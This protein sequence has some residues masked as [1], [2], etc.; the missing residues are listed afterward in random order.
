[1]ANHFVELHS[2]CALPCA[3]LADEAV[4]ALEHLKLPGNVRQLENVICRALVNRAVPATLQLRDLPLEVLSE[5][6]ANVAQPLCHLPPSGAHDLEG[7]VRHQF[8]RLIDLTHGRLD[9]SMD[10][11]E[12][13]LISVALERTRGNQSE[14]ARLLHIT[15]RSVYNKL[16]RHQLQSIPPR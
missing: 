6:A 4:E 2:A 16:R 8:Q 14:T 1:M 7:E 9:R 13:I 11:C 10:F 5:V 12:R 15:P 3:G